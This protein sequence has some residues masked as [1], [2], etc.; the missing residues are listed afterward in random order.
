MRK[1]YNR[2]LA[3]LLSA[4]I[5]FSALPVTTFAA[6][7]AVSKTELNEKHGEAS[8][9]EMPEVDLS[10]A[11]AI[12]EDRSETE[13]TDYSDGNEVQTDRGTA[14]GASAQVS[15][16]GEEE[17]TEDDAAPEPSEGTEE[18]PA[19][20]S[21]SDGEENVT[22]D[23]AAAQST[24]A[25]AEPPAEDVE[26]DAERESSAAGS[27]QGAESFPEN[28][29]TVT[30]VVEE[31][32]E[33]ADVEHE[34]NDALFEEYAEQTFE[35][36]AGGSEESQPSRSKKSSG[37][38]LTGQ[39]KIIYDLLKT[40]VS[41]IAS[42]TRTSS[43]VEIPLTA[44]D[45]D[46]EHLYTAEE[47]GLDYIYRKVNGEDVWNPEIG[48]AVNSL[49]SYDGGRIFTSLMA[50]CPYEM[51]WN[52]GG[53]SYTTG[54]GY[55]TSAS[56]S[57]GVWT[58]NVQ[59]SGT[60]ITFAF[61]LDENYRKQNGGEYEVDK[62]KTGAVT[63]AVE[64]AQSIVTA[65]DQAGKSDYERLVYYKDRICEEV[66]YND[67][68]ATDMNNYPDG[69]PWALIY[70]FDQDANTNVVCE[71]YSEAFQ[72]LCELTVFANKQVCAY[73]PTGTMAGGTGAGPHKWNIV[74][75]DDGLNYL[76]D[77]TNS[78][79]GS[80][81]ED[82][83]LFLKGVEGS[84]SAGYTFS[85][86]DYGVTVSYT[87]D[88]DTRT[89]FTDE[90]LTLSAQD[91]DPSSAPV[92]PTVDEIAEIEAVSMTLNGRI[93]MNVH[94][95]LDQ[96]YISQDDSMTFTCAGR[97]VTQKVSEAGTDE[98]GRAVF[99]LE[100][101][102]GQM[103]DQVTFFMTVG[104]SAGTSA[105]YSVRSYADAVLD[106]NSSYTDNEKAM[107]RAMLN[108]GNYTQ[109]FSGY[110]SGNPAAAGLYGEGEDPVLYGT[111][112]N[113]SDSGYLYQLNDRE[114]GIHIEDAVLLLGTDISIRFYYVPGEN[115]TA[116]SYTFTMQGENVKTVSRGYDENR[117]M[118]YADIEHFA[119]TELGEIFTLSIRKAGEG[120]ESDPAASVAFSVLS[121]CRGILESDT[122]SQEM[123]N[124]AKAICF[125]SQAAGD[126]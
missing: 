46:P 86:D 37:D 29:E 102:A 51:Y 7:P 16:E 6:R 125:Y 11:D 8:G 123:K 58:G 112:P 92:V 35:E 119:P 4:L 69:G 44:L 23:D 9:V 83:R 72:Y 19:Q 15:D 24:E 96:A 80:I 33:E 60:S 68:A 85:W 12:S 1:K 27:G 75:M 95:A 109:L 39:D 62:D 20:G 87:Y 31:V 79:N 47:L 115:K 10:R 110:N 45:I 111:S 78:D 66:I 42:G 84:V 54:L 48:T 50:D 71:G 64:F 122:S 55:R 88:N 118:Y 22:E 32:R 63:S 108:Y 3:V 59:V 99:S 103:T 52:R 65:A 113:L 93:I 120:Q 98:S 40:A 13:N 90:E 114:D 25:A 2:I 49:L 70:V 100:L 56:M 34:D 61:S 73:S 81:G 18:A 105:A 82:G 38:R 91:Y 57:G 101:A 94:V 67:D 104:E 41:E 36:A 126:M 107:A 26:E 77:V 76:A 97:T 74:H 116:D 89:L 43:E 121:Y 21:V 28:Q 106:E 117:K 30:E 53:V 14:A 5:L 124:L 17:L